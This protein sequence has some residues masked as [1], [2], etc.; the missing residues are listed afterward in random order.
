M[1]MERECDLGNR[2]IERKGK[3]RKVPTGCGGGNRGFEVKA[4]GT[5]CHNAAMAASIDRGEYAVDAHSG[6]PAISPR[7][8]AGKSRRKSLFADEL[9]RPAPGGSGIELEHLTSQF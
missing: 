5:R 9:A 7:F 3:S 8:C 4:T 6:L 2:F 1:A